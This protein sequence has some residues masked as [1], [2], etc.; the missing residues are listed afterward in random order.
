MKSCA[1]TLNVDS[2]DVLQR[3]WIAT[4][5]DQNQFLHIVV[6]KLQQLLYVYRAVVEGVWRHSEDGP[7]LDSS[8]DALSV[9]RFSVT[10]QTLDE[11]VVAACA[12][13]L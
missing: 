3:L 10:E 13:V 8:V 7:D 5:E 6:L 12:A 9:V 2:T 11:G 1:H 4:D